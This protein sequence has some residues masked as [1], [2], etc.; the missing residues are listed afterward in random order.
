MLEF[1]FDANGL[2]PDIV[3]DLESGEV[4]MVGYMDSEALKRTLQEKK[5]VF[6]SRSRKQYWVKG[7]SSGHTQEVVEVLTD[8]DR[9]TI[10]VRV[11]QRGGA[12]HLGYRSCFVNLIDHQGNLAEI[13]QKKIFDPKAVYPEK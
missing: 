1:K 2:I 11:K 5:S 3:Q 6:Y 7:E 8:C 12:C 4:L 9:D 13:T 10:L